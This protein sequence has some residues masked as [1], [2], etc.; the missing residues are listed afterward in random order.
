MSK[1]C[2]CLRVSRSHIVQQGMLFT[3][4]V[5][6]TDG[7]IQLWPE[8]RRVKDSTDVPKRQVCCIILSGTSI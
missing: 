6:L 1:D 5:W 4:G 8:G 3:Y 7:D 2:P